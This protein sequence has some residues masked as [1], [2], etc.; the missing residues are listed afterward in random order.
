MNKKIYLIQPTYRDAA[1]RLFTGKCLSYASLALPA[2]SATIPPDWEKEFCLEYF[3]QIDYDTDASLIGISSMGYDLLHGMEIADAFRRRG[4]QVVFGG[5]QAQCSTSLLESRCDSVVFG[6]PGR[7]EMELI[8]SDAAH[9]RL[10]PQY[11]FG[12]DINFAFDY[13]IFLNKRLNFY[14][15][16][17]SVG[18]KNKCEFCSTAAIYQGTYRLRS[19]NIVMQDIHQ[20][21]RHSDRIVFSD[22]NIFNNREYLLRLCER[23]ITDGLSMRWGA[24]CTLDVGDDADVLCLL[25]RAGCR[26]LLIGLETLNQADMDRFGKRIAVADHRRRVRA[27]QDAGIHAGGYFMLGLD[28]DTPDS[29]N[30]MF[31]FI[32]ETRIALPILNLLLPAPGTP[33]FERIRREGRSLIHSPEE[34]LKNNA[35][36]ATAINRCFYKPLKMTE[37]ETEQNFLALYRRLTT[38][39][40][41]LRRSLVPDPSLFLLLLLL[42]REMRR[43]YQ[44]MTKRDRSRAL[45]QFQ[46]LNLGETNQI[47]ADQSSPSVLES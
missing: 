24:Q 12:L 20:A 14:P 27:I 43:E 38:W 23:I 8:L 32:H 40:E 26:V 15:V 17:S 33:T 16:L 29:F 10:A 31:D 13:S 19:L 45:R 11:H 3:D 18:C 21:I 47:P 42:N 6:S 44:A 1:G 37:A 41:I 4:K 2:L 5:P 36:F 30:R 39:P 35:S 28:D 7:K 46:E 34:S 9:A 22:P 25:R